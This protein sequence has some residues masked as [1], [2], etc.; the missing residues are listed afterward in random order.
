MYTLLLG[1]LLILLK[2][3]EIGPVATWS[4]WWVLSPL[5]VTAAWWAWADA[6]GYTKR[7]AMEKMDKRKMDRVNK[8]KEALGMGQRKRR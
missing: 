6:T 1:L 2:Y 8:H 7:K 4:W 3:L 5:A